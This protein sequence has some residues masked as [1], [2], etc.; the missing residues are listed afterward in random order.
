MSFLLIS[1]K[2]IK[3]K[4]QRWPGWRNPWVSNLEFVPFILTQNLFCIFGFKWKT[5]KSCKIPLSSW[6]S[7]S[8]IHPCDHQGLVHV[9]CVDVTICITWNLSWVGLNSVLKFLLKVWGF[10][11]RSVL[12]I[13]TQSNSNLTFRRFS[14]SRLKFYGQIFQRLDNPKRR[15]NGLSLF[16]LWGVL[17]YFK[18]RQFKNGVFDVEVAGND[19]GLE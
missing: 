19:S 11:C 15:K 2:R 1:R 18:I 14:Q 16:N 5:T 17:E 10:I 3:K 7:A 6:L 4:V 9:C 8:L 12:R 13:G